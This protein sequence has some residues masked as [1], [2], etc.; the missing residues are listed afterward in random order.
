[1]KAKTF[2]IVCIILI[3]QCAPGINNAFGQWGSKALLKSLQ[4]YT[5]NNFNWS[6]AADGNELHVVWYDLAGSNND[7]IFHKRSTDG[8]LTWEDDIQLTNNPAQ[9]WNPAVA[10]NGP[11][12][13]VVWLDTRDNYE[14]YYKR[15][16]DAGV[17][18]SEDTQLTNNPAYSDFP[19]VAVSGQNVHLVWYD[20]RDGG[21]TGEIYYKQSTDG[22]LTWGADTR[23]T[24]DP[25]YSRAPCIAVAGQNIHVV[26]EDERNINRQVYYKRSTDGGLTWGAEIPLTEDYYQSRGPSVASSGQYVHVTWDD[27]RNGPAPEIYY[28]HS[29]DGGLTWEQD[30][31]ITNHE[32]GANYPSIAVSG[33]NIHLVWYD[34]RHANWEI[35]Y[36]RSADNG[37]SWE[38]DTRL[39][40]NPY[41]GQYPSVAVS[42]SAVHVVW[43]EFNNQ[44]FDIYYIQN[45][46][47]NPVTSIPDPST[48]AL[49]V[50]SLKPNYPNPFNQETSINYLLPKDGFVKLTV[51]DILGN[52]VETLVNEH[53]SKGTHEVTFSASSHPAGVYLI[54]L[55]TAGHSETRKIL[56]IK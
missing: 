37:I 19:S 7:E 12:V 49:S 15:S 46:T 24:N 21:T 43:Y 2:R 5:Y 56:L 18:W 38:T 55:M 48:G 3:I 52:E 20:F 53:Q 29:I 42:D 14:I 25:A 10:V 16:V 17:T 35:Y 8:G 27:F 6:V 51:S 36:N 32:T 34:Y 22:G 45:P 9:S 13:H 26:W 39:T 44:N 47:G 41:L 50:F 1:M 31:S 23:L 54:H 28:K 4:Q 30:Y 11:V 33:P 40:E